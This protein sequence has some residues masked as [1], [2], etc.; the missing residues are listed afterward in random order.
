MSELAEHSERGLA[1]PPWLNLVL[2]H[3]VWLVCILANNTLALAATILFLGIHSVFYVDH[4]K[5]WLIIAGFTLVGVIVD[6]LQMNLGYIIF[7]GS[8]KIDVVD[9]HV[10]LP[11][12]WLVCLW[13]AFATTL[14]HGLFWF[15]KHL[16]LA[17]LC[18]LVSVP[19]SYYF[20]AILSGSTLVTGVK[21]LLIEG[22]IWSILFPVGLM[23]SRQLKGQSS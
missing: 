1:S 4:K 14:A 16:K 5:E 18:A 8:I 11:P 2:F 6:S 9:T 10:L 15:A 3:L 12:I 21:F 7:S 17:A 20:G 22:A 23:F 19:V 13:I